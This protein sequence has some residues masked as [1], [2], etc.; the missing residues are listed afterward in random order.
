MKFYKSLP[1]FSISSWTWNLYY[2]QNHTFKNN[3]TPKNSNPNLRLTL[4]EAITVQPG[5]NIQWVNKLHRYQIL[6]LTVH[7]KLMKE[8]SIL[9]SG[10]QCLGINEISIAS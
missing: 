9:P 1:N 10:I 3:S 5:K 6:G 4:K 8:T 7:K 2:K